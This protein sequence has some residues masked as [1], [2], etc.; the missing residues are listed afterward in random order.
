M[1]MTDKTAR[2]V[3]KFLFLTPGL[4]TSRFAVLSEKLPYMQGV[5]CVD[6]LVHVVITK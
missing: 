3:A 6:G 2:L 5:G 4:Q 1:Q